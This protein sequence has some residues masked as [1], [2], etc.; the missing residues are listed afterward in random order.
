MAYPYSLLSFKTSNVTFIKLSYSSLSVCVC[1]HVQTH[2]HALY[3]HCSQLCMPCSPITS[4]EDLEGTFIHLEVLMPNWSLA[5][6]RYLFN[7]CIGDCF[8]ATRQGGYF[9]D[10]LGEESA[11]WVTEECVGCLYLFLS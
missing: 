2:M 10:S 7:I 4:I 5:L 3:V 8:C 6:S 9:N 11:D 1:V